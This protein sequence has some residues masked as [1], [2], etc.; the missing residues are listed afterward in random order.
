MATMH[1]IGRRLGNFLLFFNSQPRS[2]L[3]CT[4]R[5]LVNAIGIGVLALYVVESLKTTVGEIQT[6]QNALERQVSGLWFTQ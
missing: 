1:D 5:Q 2:A 4:Q 3:A 6:R